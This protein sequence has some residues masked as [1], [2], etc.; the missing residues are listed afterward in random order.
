MPRENKTQYTILGALN[1]EPLS[2]YDIKRGSVRLGEF[3]WSESP[4]QIYPTL[5]KLLKEGSVKL[6][7]QK[8]KGGRV[9]KIYSIT[10]EGKKKLQDWLKE[11]AEKEVPRNELV[12]KLYLGANI[13]LNENIQHME[14]HLKKMQET[15]D[16]YQLVYKR[17]KEDNRMDARALAWEIALKHAFYH[18]EAELAWSDEVLKLLKRKNR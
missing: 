12:L 4:G 5:A 9:K 16:R 14:Q 10:K 8:S 18:I 6:E 1:V 2:G 11:P 15:F 7:T 17:L 13:S 3:F